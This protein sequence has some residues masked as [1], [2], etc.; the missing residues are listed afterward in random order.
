V[1]EKER[2][3]RTKEGERRKV[4]GDKDGRRESRV[5]E[6][7]RARKKPREKRSKEG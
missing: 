2:G 6:R 4:K 1:I 5:R 7:E 3:D